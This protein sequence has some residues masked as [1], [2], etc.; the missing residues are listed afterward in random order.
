M[1]VCHF[2]NIWIFRG[3]AI[4]EYLHAQLIH[5]VHYVDAAEMK[6]NPLANMKRQRY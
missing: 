1:C 3:A 6:M 4:Y 2:Q 5:G